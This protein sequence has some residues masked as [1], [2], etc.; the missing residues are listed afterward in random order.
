[1]IYCGIFPDGNYI[2]KQRLED[3]I[4]VPGIEH[5][6]KVENSSGNY[7]DCIFTLITKSGAPHFLK[8]NNIELRDISIEVYD[9]QLNK[10]KATVTLYDYDK[11]HTIQ[12][13]IVTNSNPRFIKDELIPLMNSLNSDKSGSS[14]TDLEAL[15]RENNELKHKLDLITNQLS[16]D[17]FKLN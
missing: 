9:K 17:I 7:L 11:E 5:Y 1:M 2:E 13:D 14:L 15:Q 4:I 8:I 16:P 3:I 6:L 10:R 12:R